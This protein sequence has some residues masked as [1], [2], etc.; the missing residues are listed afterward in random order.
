MGMKTKNVT[1]DSYNSTITSPCLTINYN[2]WSECCGNPSSLIC[3]IESA[4]YFV[5]FVIILILFVTMI[6][7]NNYLMLRDHP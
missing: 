3:S 2:E 5:I 1:P 7:K 6:K 4:P